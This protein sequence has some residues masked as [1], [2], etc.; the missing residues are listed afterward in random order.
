MLLW[1][2]SPA[3]LVIEPDLGAFL[4]FAVCQVNR[5]GGARLGEKV[6]DSVGSNSILDF[7]FRQLGNPVIVM[8]L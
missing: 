8:L 2:L 1:P 6:P 3:G 4:P 5:D 7:V